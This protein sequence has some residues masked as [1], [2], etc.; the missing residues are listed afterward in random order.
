MKAKG[1]KTFIQTH[2]MVTN[3]SSEFVDSNTISAANQSLRWLKH[4]S[5]GL[6]IRS[7]YA[8]QRCVCDVTALTLVSSSM[9]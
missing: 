5:N 1:I 3:T 4:C 6:E 8:R 2:D 7:L 9:Q